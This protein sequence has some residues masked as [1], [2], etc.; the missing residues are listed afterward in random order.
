MFVDT[1]GSCLQ[2]ALQELTR[3]NRWSEM[4]WRSF[5][6]L[7]LTL[8]LFH[9]FMGMRTVVQDYTKGNLRMFLTMLLYLLDE[10]LQGTNTAER[11]VAAAAAL[12]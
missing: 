4:F 11:Q 7:M 1:S 6:W 5:D 9:A 2:P 8:V 10:V 12:S 3:Q